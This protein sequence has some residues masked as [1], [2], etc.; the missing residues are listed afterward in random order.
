MK[1]ENF[2]VEQLSVK[3]I[4]SLTPV[5]R[6]AV[7]PPIERFSG[8]LASILRDRSAM[9]WIS[10]CRLCSVD[11]STVK[12]FPSSP[13]NTL[14]M[15]GTDSARTTRRKKIQI[16]GTIAKNPQKFYWQDFQLVLCRD[17]LGRMVLVDF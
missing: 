15:S 3:R 8:S 17:W 7:P 13:S 14:S 2:I 11:F 6:D 4:S 16:S 5:F 1:I 9:N 10:C 12:S